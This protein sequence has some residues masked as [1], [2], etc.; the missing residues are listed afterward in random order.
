MAVSCN[1][2]FHSA[3]AYQY[4][5]LYCCTSTLVFRE[6]GLEARHVYHYTLLAVNTSTPN[7]RDFRFIIQPAYLNIPIRCYSCTPNLSVFALLSVCNTSLQQTSLGEYHTHTHLTNLAKR[8]SGVL[9]HSNKF[10]SKSVFNFTIHHNQ[11]FESN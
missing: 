10:S 6:S 2:N 7:S 3:Y 8:I 9:T 11:D 1:P 4:K 5:F